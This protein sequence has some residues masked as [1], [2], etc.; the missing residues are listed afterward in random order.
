MVGLGF[1]ETLQRHPVTE[2]YVVELVDEG[3]DALCP[4]LEIGRVGFPKHCAFVI[5][6]D[7]RLV[8]GLE[9]EFFFP[10]DFR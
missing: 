3:D 5:E 4:G 2:G 10:F 1:G 6:L 8:R 7:E 9:I